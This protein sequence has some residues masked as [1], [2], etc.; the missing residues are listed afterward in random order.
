MGSFRPSLPPA[1]AAVRSAVREALPAE[2][3][4]LVALSGGRDS[5]A[6][7]S[8]AA[9]EAPRRVGAVIVDHGL[10]DGSDAVARLSRKR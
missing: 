7:C 5:L 3:F 10:K 4:V 1:V 2:G 6:L 8:A 9:F